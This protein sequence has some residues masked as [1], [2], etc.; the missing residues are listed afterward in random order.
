MSDIKIPVGEATAAQLREHATL[1]M[2]LEIDGRASANTIL[3]KMREAGFDGE[4]ITVLLPDAPTVPRVD[5]EEV[6]NRK[7]VNGRKFRRINIPRQDI[8]GGEEPVPVGVNGRVMFVPRGE[9]C[10]V[11]EDYIEVLNHAVQ[12]IYEAYDGSNQLGLR[13]PRMVKSYPFSYV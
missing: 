11:P 4:E 2:G 12:A 6:G 7:T 1:R 8:P 10:W 13:K 9:D 3:A 5:P